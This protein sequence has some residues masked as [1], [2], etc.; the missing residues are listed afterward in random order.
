MTMFQLLDSIAS[1]PDGPPWRLYCRRAMPMRH[2]RPRGHGHARHGIARGHARHP[3]HV[4]F[5]EG[6]RRG[7]RG[8]GGQ[9]RRR[10]RRGAVLRLRRRSRP[11]ARL[12]PA[13]ME[14]RIIGTSSCPR[15]RGPLIPGLRRETGA[16][17]D[18]IA[19]DARR[20]GGEGRRRSRR[21]RRRHGLDRTGDGDAWPR[22]PGRRRGRRAAAAREAR[23]AARQQSEGPMHRA[24]LGAAAVALR[25][26]SPAQG[27]Q[28]RIA[29][30]RTRLASTTAHDRGPHAPNRTTGLPRVLRIAAA[31]RIER[32]SR[33]PAGRGTRR[34]G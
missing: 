26:A 31:A 4:G 1:S 19:E 25:D 30:A 29:R 24:V 10:G 17:R 32:R 8:P 13:K 7:R 34:C 15:G 11:T 9:A 20:R 16:R 28:A 14:R 6:G 22:A 18:Q 5:E 2:E 33:P 23:R 27:G 12:T 3:A 21:R